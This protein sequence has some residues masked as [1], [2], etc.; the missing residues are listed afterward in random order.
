MLKLIAKVIGYVVLPAILSIQIILNLFSKKFR[1]PLYH[2]KS[3][4]FYKKIGDYD[5]EY[6]KVQKRVNHHTHD[7]KQKDITIVLVP[8]NPG[9]VRYY[10]LFL[11]QLAQH[12]NY[13]YDIYAICHVGHLGFEGKKKKYHVETDYKHHHYHGVHHNNQQQT[14]KK[15]LNVLE[16]QIEHKVEFMKYLMHKHPNTKFIF[17]SHSIG[18]YI[19]LNILD[20]LPKDKILHCFKLF[21]TIERMNEMPNYKHTNI[22]TRFPVKQVS[23][24]IAHILQYLPNFVKRVLIQ[25]V[26]SNQ[27]QQE[28]IDD[29][30]ETVTSFLDYTTVYN[31]S[32]MA[33]LEFTFVR[34]RQDD[35][36]KKYINE[37]TLYYGR[38]D[39]WATVDLYHQI[40]KD[41]PAIDARLD[42]H[43]LEHAFVVGGARTQAQ[44]LQDWIND[45]IKNKY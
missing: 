39:N 34:K 1:Q 5:T 44:L 37:I 23:A 40:K 28:P 36:L 3:Q 31:I 8:G 19:V 29:I 25:L 20:Y 41:I 27:N 18:S 14:P 24:T 2:F 15:K 4:Y 26:L 35:L 21:P 30:V 17:V 13:A 9:Y 11:N 45:K 10:D 43:N 12:L 32:N 38:N 33:Q 22:L 7:P 16:H 42:D 6:L